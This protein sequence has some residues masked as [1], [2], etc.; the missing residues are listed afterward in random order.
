MSES[1]SNNLKFW[2]KY[3]HARQET[4]D[5][6]FFVRPRISLQYQDIENE[7]YGA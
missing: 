6:K 1:D 7:S 3:L 5:V 2:K 4:T